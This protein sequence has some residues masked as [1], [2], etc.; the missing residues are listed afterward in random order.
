MA[1]LT[2]A[3]IRPSRA[4]DFWRHAPASQRSVETA[5]GCR[6]AVG[7]GEAP[8]L[9]Q[10]TISLWDSAQA[11]DAFAHTGAHRQATLASQRGQHF[12]ESM[13]IRFVPI[14]VQGVW[15]GQRLG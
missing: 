14:A 5:D 10:A 2:R 6:L 13:F 8:L 7:L 1:A 11:M 4:L 12:S 9:R 15:K 3:S